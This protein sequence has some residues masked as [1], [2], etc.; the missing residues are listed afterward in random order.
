MRRN[1]G[2][3][4]DMRG[5]LGDGEPAPVPLRNP[6]QIRRGRLERG[7]RGAMA[8]TVYAMARATVPHK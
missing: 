1:G 3:A 4:I 6:R 5:Y 2:P 8:M 7:R